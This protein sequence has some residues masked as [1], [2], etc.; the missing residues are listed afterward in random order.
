MIDQSRLPGRLGN[1]DIRFE[2][3]ARADPRIAAVVKMLGGFGGGVDLL[4]ADA[5]YEQCL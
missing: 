5:S 4:P 3:D 1:D 2:T